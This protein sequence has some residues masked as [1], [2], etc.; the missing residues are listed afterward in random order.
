MKNRTAYSVQRTALAILSAVLLILSFPGFNIW[1]LAWVGLVPLLFAI[2]DET[3]LKAFLLS[4]LTGLLFFFGTIYWLIHVTLLGM[5]AAVVIL[6]GYFGLFGLLMAYRPPKKPLY[7]LFFVPAAW[8]AT[9]WLRSNL[10]TGFGWALIGHS[11]SQNLPVI[12]IADI[13][14]AYGVSFLLVT[15]NAA[16]YLLLKKGRL[17]EDLEI[18]ILITLILV[19]LAFGYGYYRLNNIFTGEKMRV[20]VIQGNIPQVKKWDAAYREEILSRYERLTMEAGNDAADL[21]V[22]PETSVPGVLEGERRLLERM[23]RLCAEVK[24]PLFLGTIRE[25]RKGPHVYYNSATLLLPDGRVKGSYDKI[26]LVP[27]GEYVPLKGIFGF[28]EKIA[29]A[30]IGD[31]SRGKE[32]TV[33]SVPIERETRSDYASWR[34]I[35][36]AKFSAL[37]CF[38][39]VFPELSREFV[40]HGA[41]FLVNIT[42]DAWYKETPAAYQHAQSS[43][44]RAVEN[45]TNVVR[46]ANTGFSCFI[47]Q[48]GRVVKSVEKDGANL[49]VDGFASHDIVLANTRTFYTVYGDTIVYASWVL[50]LTTIFGYDIVGARTKGGDRWPRK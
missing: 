13:F 15:A 10:F 1:I 41:R 50:L 31:V 2:K 40:R 8:V 33:F 28:V 9:E 42:N 6:A 5:L 35:K 36:R 24:T 17:A 27:F 30:P 22:W 34:L 43:V 3:P 4:Y 23:K 11:Q 18:P 14:G 29:P 39:D 37:I 44:F 45:R 26:H 47:D 25:D 12:Q 32:Y 46:A 21:I 20:A 16:I 7:L 38:E 19:L 49:S 48:K